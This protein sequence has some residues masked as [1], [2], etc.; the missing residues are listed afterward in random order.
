MMQICLKC[1]GHNL[2]ADAPLSPPRNPGSFPGLYHM[3]RLLYAG[4]CFKMTVK[5]S[6][7]SKLLTT[8]VQAHTYQTLSNNYNMPICHFLKAKAFWTFHIDRNYTS[9]LEFNANEMHDNNHK[10]YSTL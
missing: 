1:Y 4:D 6:I 10:K 5:R 9:E 3:C 7:H 2:Y 8:K